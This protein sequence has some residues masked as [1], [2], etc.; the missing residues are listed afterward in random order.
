MTYSSYRGVGL[1]LTSLVLAL[2]AQPVLAQ[3]EDAPSP[4]MRS[5][6]ST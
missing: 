2:Q 3:G 1:V 4:S 5:V 6:V